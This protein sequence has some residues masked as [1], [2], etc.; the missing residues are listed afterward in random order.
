MIYVA[1]KCGK[2]H[3]ASEDTAL[4]GTEIFVNTNATVPFPQLGFICVADGVGGNCGGAK[5]SNYICTALAEAEGL[6]PD[7]LQHYL[8]EENE[9]LIQLSNKA[10]EYSNM[11]TTLSGVY[12]VDD[13]MFLFHVGNSRVYAKQG[14]YLKQL[15]ADH[16][17]YNW[18][19]STGNAEA[20]QACNKS[21]ITN[22]FGGGNASLI[23][24]L[25][26]ARCNN[27]SSL[28]LTTDGIHDYV[29]IDHLESI[30]NEDAAGE[31][32][33]LQILSL[34]QAAGSKDDLTVILAC[35]D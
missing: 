8:C 26:V 23:S 31:E 11:A 15:T 6:H 33:C 32:K 30:L 12:V 7:M 16:T 14:N 28:L 18:L 5:A 2:S 20:A 1:T 10:S 21:E 22:C 24:K 27:F 4:V 19:L 25:T 34:A 13:E 29:D 3:S 17:T 35:R 9:A